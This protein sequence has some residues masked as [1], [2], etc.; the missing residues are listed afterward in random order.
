MDMQREQN[1]NQQEQGVLLREFAQNF[2]LVLA[3]LQEFVDRNNLNI[4]RGPM[5]APMPGGGAGPMPGGGPGWPGGGGP[6]G[7]APPGGDGGDGGGGDGAFRRRRRRPDEEEE[8]ETPP[9]PPPDQQG[10]AIPAGLPVGHPPAV[11]AEGERA[12]KAPSPGSGVGHVAAQAA[13][14]LLPTAAGV[15]GSVAGSAL[16]AAAM[17]TAAAFSTS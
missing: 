8:E 10:Q 6:G 2:G 11:E 5:P 1:N 4:R 9:P 12:K 14:V 17:G 3:N 16:A 7:G 15:A 13:H